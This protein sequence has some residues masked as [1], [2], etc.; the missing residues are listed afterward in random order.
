MAVLQGLQ[1]RKVHKVHK[2][3]RNGTVKVREGT[4]TAAEM[5]T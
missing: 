2:V 5:N 4:I 1:D 3:S